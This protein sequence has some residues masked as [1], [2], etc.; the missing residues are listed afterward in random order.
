M[1]MNNTTSTNNI[2][3][4]HNSNNSHNNSIQNGK[5]VDNRLYYAHDLRIEQY[6]ASLHLALLS[7]TS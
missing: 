3:P 2:N 1:V 5:S 6:K 4:I 7:S